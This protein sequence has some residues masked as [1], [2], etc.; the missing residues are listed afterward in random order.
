M[1][2]THASKNPDKRLQD[3]VRM[4]NHLTDALPISEFEIEKGGGGKLG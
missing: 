1:A 3:A 4:C 2:Q